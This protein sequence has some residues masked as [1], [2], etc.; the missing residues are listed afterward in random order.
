MFWRF[1]RSIWFGWCEWRLFWRTIDGEQGLG[2]LPVVK[3]LATCLMDPCG[4]GL[5]DLPATQGPIVACRRCHGG[6][7]M[8]TFSDGFAD[9]LGCTSCGSVHTRTTSMQPSSEQCGEGLGDLHALEGATEACGRCHG[10]QG[11]L[12]FN[13]GFANGLG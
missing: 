2:D 4:E 9:G 13:D 6:K 3:D 10:G 7:G 1:G 11:M 5:G 8:L 12:T